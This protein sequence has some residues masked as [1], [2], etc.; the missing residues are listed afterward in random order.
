[1]NSMRSPGTPQGDAGAGRSKDEARGWLALWDRLVRLGFGE[2]ALRLGTNIL[3]ILLFLGVIW[4]MSTFY[5]HGPSRM[6]PKVAFSAL[7]PTPTITLAPPPLD[8]LNPASSLPGLNPLALIHTNQSDRPRFDIVRY[9]VQP[10]DTLFGIA[11]QFNLSPQTILWGNFAVL[12]DDPE[13]LMPGQQL[14]I[15]PVDGV[16]YQWRTGDGLNGVAKFFDVTP[17]DIIDWPGNHLSRATLG[18]L[19]S[20]SIPD[21]AMLVVPGGTREFTSWSAPRVV[22][23]DPTAGKGIGA[24]ACGQAATGAVG[25]GTYIWPTTEHSISGYTY[26]PE[27]NHPAIDI[28][29]QEGNPV[30][31]VDNGVVVYAGFSDL[32]YGNMVMIDHGDGWQSLYAHLSAVNV[33]CGQSLYQGAVIGAVGSTGNSSG[34]HLHFELRSDKLGKVNPLQYLPQ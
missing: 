16:L 31:A 4:V 17:D 25:V 18:D 14:N 7:Q 15:L 9:T 24:G 28:G 32:G 22:R 3:S 10:G 2:T 13:R 29:G 19:T 8:H 27:T 21:K 33:S 23:T 6:Q 30:Y 1:M 11:Q 34:P 12:A 26:S 20:P 5:V